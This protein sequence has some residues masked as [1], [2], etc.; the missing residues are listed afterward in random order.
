M[1]PR[2]VKEHTVLMV[3]DDSSTRQMI[4]KILSGTSKIIDSIDPA[5]LVSIYQQYLPDM[6]LMDAQ[7]CFKNGGD[8]I[9]EILA[10]DP[11][12]FIV[13]MGRDCTEQSIL[14]SKKRGV[15]GFICKPLQREALLR[16]ITLSVSRKTHA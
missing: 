12:A 13:L 6:V 11:H 16:Y 5:M 8:S 3:D 4:R 10:S 7:T 1:M 9:K 2:K 14:E 15:R